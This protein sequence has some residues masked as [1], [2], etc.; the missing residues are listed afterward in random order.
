MA[1]ATLPSKEMVAAAAELGCSLRPGFRFHP[2]EQE[3][4][5]WFLRSKV[6]GHAGLH[7]HFIPEVNVYRFEPHQLPGTYARCC[8]TTQTHSKKEY[9]RCHQAHE[10]N[11]KSYVSVRSNLILRVRTIFAFTCQL[12]LHI[13]T[14][15]MGAVGID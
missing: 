14:C 5:G 1:G 11:P 6:L 3:L 10:Y 15:K 8:T 9:K 13:Y 7:V 12:N 2:T 4:V